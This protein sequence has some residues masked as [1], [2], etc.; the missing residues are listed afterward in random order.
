M[1]EV[2]KGSAPFA[3]DRDMAVHRLTALWALNESG[4]GG[5]MHAMKIPFTGVLVGG[6]AVLIITLIACFAE[7]KGR[8]ILRG[9]LF[10]V[11]IKAAASP[12]TPLPAYFAVAFQ[13][14]L[15]AL[16]F[17]LLP[18]TRLPAMLLA[19]AALAEGA[20]QK[21]I[22]MTLVFGGSLWRS[23]D[24]AGRRI[25]ASFHLP[26]PDD[27]RFSL[28]VVGVVIASH[29]AAGVLVGAVAGGLPGRLLRELE[30]P[31]KGEAPTREEPWPDRGAVS[32]RRWRKRILHW[33]LLFV[34]ILLVLGLLDS[35]GSVL[36]RLLRP[37]IRTAAA[38]AVWFL[39]VAPL[40]RFLLFRLLR[41]RMRGH[42]GEIDDLQRLLPRMRVLA[43]SAWRD[44]RG[45]RPWRRWPDFLIRLVARALTEP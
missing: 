15:G 22:V 19:V 18:R 36:H 42:A 6:T 2:K 17:S 44:T 12:H 21:L 16:L 40:F 8:A 11:V 26:V 25:A 45:C 20:A 43:G 30:R 23:V 24:L 35:E 39:V 1:G 31:V 7:R 28:L 37:I 29:V 3:L 41:G 5:F 13:G 14:F 33:S 34:L 38:L 32:G 27:Y 4:L 9:M 10:V